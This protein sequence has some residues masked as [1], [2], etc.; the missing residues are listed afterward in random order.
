MTSAA[1]A[2]VARAATA[3]S[4]EQTEPDQ[5]ERQ[6]ADGPVPALSLPRIL[7]NASVDVVLGCPWSWGSLERH[8][9]VLR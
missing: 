3:E 1:A 4:Y 8:S 7:D 9:N 2:M 6:E 5:E